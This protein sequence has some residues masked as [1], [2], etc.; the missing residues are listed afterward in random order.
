MTSPELL[1]QQ[2]LYNVPQSTIVGMSPFADEGIEAQGGR[3]CSNL[4]S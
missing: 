2:L 1:F 3:P 4:H